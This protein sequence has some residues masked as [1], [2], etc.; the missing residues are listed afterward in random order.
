ME[1]HELEE[2]SGWLA[3]GSWKSSLKKCISIGTSFLLA[4]NFNLNYFRCIFFLFAIYFFTQFFVVLVVV[5]DI[6]FSLIRAVAHVQIVDS[7]RM[8]NQYRA[9]PEARDNKTFSSKFYRNQA[10]V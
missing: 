1:H 4:L 3:G 5:V 2:K 8:K 7:E 10:V 9:D 6:M